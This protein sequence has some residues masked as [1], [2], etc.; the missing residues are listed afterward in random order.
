MQKCFNGIFLIPFFILSFSLIAQQSSVSPYSRL[1]I[2]D[3]QPQNYARALGFGGANLA[4]KEP[5]NI[6]ST[7]PASYT[8]IDLTTFE[9][10]MQFGLL[11]QKQRNPDVVL[12][13]NISGIRYFSIGVPLTDWWGSAAGL[14]P[15]S[16]K[17]YN[18]T[19]SRIG[20]DEI[21]I[22][23]QFSG[24]GGL[25]KL[26]WGNAFKLAEGLSLG[27]N[28]SYYF[29]KLQEQNIILW[30]GPYYNSIVDENAKIS[31]FR[32]DFGA[33]YIYEINEKSDLAIGLTFAN[34]S[35]LKADV[36]RYAYVTNNSGLS[37][38][39]L[40]A[41]E[42]YD[43][44]MT[45]PNEFGIGFTYGR[46]SE[47]ALNYAWAIN[48]DF[49]FYQGSGFTSYNGRQNL[50]DGYRMELGGFV[51]PALAV[52]GG[53]RKN[54]YLGLVEYRLGGFYENTPFAVAG[55]QLTDYGITF[56]LG[57]PVRQRNLAPGEVKNSM[58][59]LGVILGRRGT[60]ENGLIQ[61]SYLNFYLGISLND[62]W[63][64]KYKY[65]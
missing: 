52:K 23:D 30:D 50:Q 36:D 55:T 9:V 21:A 2:G 63:F 14:Q 28:T 46:K 59:N 38:D 65:R 35:N 19:T 5:L 17:G 53:E 47:R 42:S 40:D 15:Y 7:N 32:F 64:I 27:V 11:E 48:G 18:I 39:S 61:E 33:R 25:N 43:E 26:Y 3:Y 37:I 31:G 20:P 51:T 60:L 41:V 49:Q 12:N 10:G 58:I 62:K 57:L 4:L 29:G 6:N 13:N 22:D 56:G 54:N 44:N 8:A 24:S 45:M 1:G 34:Q 16:L